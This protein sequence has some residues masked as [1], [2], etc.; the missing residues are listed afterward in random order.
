MIT[1]RRID[2]VSADQHQPIPNQT[3]ANECDT[4]ADTCCLGKNFVILQ[5]TTRLADVYPYDKSYKP[6]EGVPIVS[7]ATAWDDTLTGQT[8]I[9]VVNEA[10]YYG[11]RLEH[12]LINPNQVR[13]FGIGFWDNPY[14]PNRQLQIDVNDEISISMRTSGTKIFFESRSPTDQELR[15][16]PHIEITSKREWNPGTVILGKTIVQQSGSGPKHRFIASTNALPHRT[17]YEYLDPLSDDALLHSTQPSLAFLHEQLKAKERQVSAAQA[18]DEDLRDIPPRRTYTSTDRHAKATAEAIADRFGIGIERARATMAATTQRGTR[19]AILPISRRY[20]A[21]RMFEVK[22]L[23]GKFSTDTLWYKNRTIRGNVASQVYSHK[24]GFTAIYHLTKAN[25]EQVGNSLNDFVHEYGAPSHLTYDG[26]AVQIG[27]KTRFTNSIRKYDIQSH[28]SGPR[29]PN[30]NP[31]EAAIRELKKRWYRIQSRKQVPN[32]LSDYGLTYVSETGNLTVNS[33]RYSDGR[34]PI[35]IITGCTPDISEYMDFGFYDWVTFR[36]NAGLG[37]VE[38]GR[39]LGVSHRV[40]RLMSYWIL[41]PSGIPISCS[42]VQR[43]TNLEQS[44]EEWKSRM[45]KFEH[46]LQTKWSAP[47]SDLTDTIHRVEGG[48]ILDLSLEDKDFIAEYNRVISDEELKDADEYEDWNYGEKDH[49]INMELG[50]PRGREGD[51]ELGTVKRRAVDRDGKPVGKAHT[52]PLLDHRQYEVE[53]HDGRIETM[54]ANIIAENLL[55]QVDEEGRRHLMIDEIEDHR[56][57]PNA[58]PRSEGT[59]VTRSGTPRKKRTTRGWELYVRWKGGSGDWISLKDVKN[60]YPVELAEYAIHNKID[61][62][63]AFAWWVPYVVK[64]RLAI[65]QKVKSKYWERTHKYGIRIPKT[66]QEAKEIDQQNG[67]TLWMDAIRQEMRNCRVAF[68][69]YDGNVDDL[70]GYQR[71]TGHMVFDVKLAEN[72]RRKARFVADGHKTEAPT[73]ITYSTVV[74]RDSVRIML[75]VAALNDLEVLGADIQNAFLSAPNLE[76]IWMKA[77][78]E[79]GPEQGKT[80]IVVRALYGLKSASAA[81]RAFMAEKLDSIGFKSSVADPDV[82]LRPAVKSD[83]EEYYEYV[84]MYVDDILTISMDPRQILK[85]L[86]GG[87]VRYKKGKVEKPDVYLGAKL[88]EKAINGLSCWTISSVDYVK[89]AIETV[90]NATKG[91][92]WKLP[93]RATTPMA[94]SYVPELDDTPELENWDHQFFQELIGMLRWASELGRVDILYEV[95][96]LSQYQAMPREGHLSQALHIF[97]YLKRKPKLTLYMD[98]SLPNIDY[99]IFTTR[100]EDFLEYYRDAEEEKPYR[101]PKPRGRPVVTTA[102]V[103]S[104]HAANKVTRKSHS[105]HILFVNRAPIKWHSGRQRTVETSAFSSEFIALKWCIEDIEYLRFKLRMFGIPILND[106]PTHV[107]CDNE[108]VVKNSTKVDSS[109]H[110]KHSSVAYHFTRWCVAAGIVTI[111]WIHTAENLADAMT[112]RL[113]EP[114]R[115]YLFGNWTY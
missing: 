113:S 80:F 29:R 82:W 39:W 38:I 26:A 11:T 35:E 19:S 104:S 33:S 56:I 41:P 53:F 21:D 54:T 22:R 72:F 28:V 1:K 102:F 30:E 77:G 81:F 34:T 16:C 69:T 40:G 105:G 43:L 84:M 36:Q 61:T 20:H 66:V 110:K 75:L 50:I 76:K 107:L 108:S 46:N 68:Q 44:T 13:D 73:G 45:V 103:D 97:A 14:D 92:R 58:I 2:A 67:D 4:N 31:S 62:E 91:N 98:P 89:A 52:N 18:Y 90:E 12:S 109:L 115:D 88:E 27:S 65:I 111:G 74:S 48:K 23:K 10:L 5:Y 114:V 112:K 71:I 25:G 86:E 78:P 8:Y 7:G 55:A 17:T 106:E 37:E 87:T 94:S 100:R 47:S 93:S 24:C 57:L 3:A 79:F 42:T 9:L 83:G 15:E 95:S 70:I 101:M 64:K 51:M 6:I 60:S 96:V 32:R 85:N 63:P 49:Y 59:Y 99:G